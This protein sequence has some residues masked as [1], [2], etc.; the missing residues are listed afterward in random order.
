MHERMSITEI[1]NELLRQ[2][3]LSEQLPYSDYVT[4]CQRRGVKP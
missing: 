4:E 2:L 1:S 3:W